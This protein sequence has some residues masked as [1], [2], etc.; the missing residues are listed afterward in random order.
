MPSEFHT[1]QQNK[2]LSEIIIEMTSSSPLSARHDLSTPSSGDKANGSA[3]QPAKPFVFSVAIPARSTY[4][5]AEVFLQGCG[6]CNRWR[7][8]VVVS[9]AGKFAEISIGVLKTEIY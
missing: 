1:L 5:K 9:W 8:P 6:A 7:R 2:R 3:A 4:S